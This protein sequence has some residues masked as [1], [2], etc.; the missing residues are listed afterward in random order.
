MHNLWNKFCNFHV[1][2][3]GNPSYLT[4]NYRTD[5]A[6]YDTCSISLTIQ[7]ILIKCRKIASSAVRIYL[8]NLSDPLRQYRYWNLLITE[9]LLENE[10]LKNN[11]KFFPFF[12]CIFS[13]LWVSVSNGARIRDEFIPRDEIGE[14]IT[15]Q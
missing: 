9:T 11:L 5:R 14:Q 15:S 2:F 7:H 6:T 12:L 3:K 1:H 10:H 13:L 4:F 8:F